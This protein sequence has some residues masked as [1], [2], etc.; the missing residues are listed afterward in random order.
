MAIAATKTKCLNMATPRWNVV[1]Y[2]SHPDV[3]IRILSVACGHLLEHCAPRIA[4]H[5]FDRRIDP[6]A[7]TRTIRRSRRDAR[8]SSARL[9]HATRIGSRNG[10][11]ATSVDDCR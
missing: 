7:D 5:V 4:V 6:R 2:Y 10:G 3:D 8:S 1:C 9:Q 11:S